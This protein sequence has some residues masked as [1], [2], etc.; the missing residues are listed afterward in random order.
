MKVYFTASITGKKYYEKNYCLIVKTLKSLG[1]KLIFNDVFQKSADEIWNQSR[2]RDREFYKFL[3]GCLQKCDFLVAEISY[4]SI[5]VG[6]EIATALNMAKPVLVLYSTEKVV[7]LLGGIEGDQ[8]IIEQYNLT[9][10][11]SVI[12]TSLEFLKENKD[13]RFTMLL[14]P[15]VVRFL[16]NISKKRAVPKSVY[17]RKLIE[18]DMEKEK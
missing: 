8:L 14:S 10:L 3:R 6:F 11:K 7:P 13:L 16:N 2:E 18:G 12:K 1:Y 4:P 17:I 15:K 5:S 9:N